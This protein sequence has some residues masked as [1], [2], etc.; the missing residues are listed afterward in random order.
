MTGHSERSRHPVPKQAA[1]RSVGTRVIWLCILLVSVG[2]ALSFLSHGFS[3]QIDLVS[4]VNEPVKDGVSESRIADNVMPVFDGQ[5][6]SDQGRT[7]VMTVVEDFKQVM[8]LFVGESYRPPV[9]DH[10]QVGFFQG[11]QQFEIASIALGNGQFP[12]QA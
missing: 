10:H 5:L 4:I 1:S 6:Y 11:G 8:S 3:F 9:I 7:T 2:Q 12:K